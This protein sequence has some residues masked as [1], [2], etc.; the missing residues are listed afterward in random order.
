MRNIVVMPCFKRIEMLALALEAIKTAPN[1]PDDIRIFLDTA[2]N[3]KDVEYVQAAFFPSATIIHQEPHVEALSGTWNILASLKAGYESGADFIYM[4]EEDCRIYPAFFNWHKSI[5]GT[6]PYV[7]STKFASCGRW[8]SQYGKEK[9]YTN[10]GA[11]LSRGL[12]GCIVP[13]INDEFFKDRKGYLNTHFDLMENASDLDDGL[14]RRVIKAV[15]AQVYYP[16]KPVVA[17]QGFHAYQKFVEYK[18]KGTIAERIENLRRMLE[19]VNPANRYTRDYEPYDP[20]G[21]IG[22]T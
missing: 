16:L 1:A 11:C 6:S 20:N 4:I 8:P 21:T 13:H 9:F 17:H 15:G 18:N 7:S 3:R 19:T 2:G 10:P 5:Q 12:L 14:V 22:K